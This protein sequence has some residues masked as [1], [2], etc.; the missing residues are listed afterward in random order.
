[1]TGLQVG[2]DKAGSGRGLFQVTAPRF[3]GRYRGKPRKFSFMLHAFPNI[4]NSYVP[5]VYKVGNEYTYGQWNLIGSSTTV[6]PS[7]L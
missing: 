2:K 4:C 3:A 5:D 6:L 1:M 7:P